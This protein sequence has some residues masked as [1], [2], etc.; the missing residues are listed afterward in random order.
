MLSSVVF[1][2]GVVGARFLLLTGAFSVSF[3]QQTDEHLQLILVVFLD[4]DKGM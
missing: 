1:C 2:V 3:C 4:I